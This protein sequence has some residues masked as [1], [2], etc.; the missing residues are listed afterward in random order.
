[1]AHTVLD[2]AALPTSVGREFGPSD[3]V[4]IDQRRIDL[5]ADATGD[6]QWI[7]T[8]PERAKRESPFGKTI[9][10]GHL[11]LSLAPWLLS[12]LLEVSGVGWMVNPGFDNVRMRAPVPVDS[13]IRMSATLE[14]ARVLKGGGVRVTYRIR[15][16]IEGNGRAAALGSVNVVYYPASEPPTSL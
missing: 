12:Q 15:Y 11:T 8:D 10:H 13:R 7:H 9:A 4:L 5:F 2:I 1:M 16:E 3:W 14:K 6:H